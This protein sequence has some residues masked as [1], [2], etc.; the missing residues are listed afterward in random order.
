MPSA[1]AV[2]AIPKVEVPPLP[3]FSPPAAPAA[4]KPKPSYLPLIIIL[5]VL[6]FVAILLV[7]Y[8]AVKR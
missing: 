1:P 2:P 5:N 8:F 4:P 3:K 6:L 7:V